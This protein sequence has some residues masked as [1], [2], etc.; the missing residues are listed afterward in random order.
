MGNDP[1]GRR[2]MGRLFA[3]SQ[4]GIEMVVPIALG[5]WLD[6]RW[7]TSPWLV[8]VGAVVGLVGGLTHLIYLLRKFERQP[9]SP[10]QD[11]Q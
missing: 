4:V 5:V 8:A 1:S 7:G 6:K 11:S 10:P 2:E 3:L 9:P